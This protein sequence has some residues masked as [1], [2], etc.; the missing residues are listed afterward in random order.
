VEPVERFLGYLTSIE[1]S[2]NTV[3]AYAHDLKDWDFPTSAPAS[4]PRRVSANPPGPARD[5]PRA[6]SAARHPATQS[7]RKAAKRT[8]KKPKTTP[9]R[10]KRKLRG[11]VLQGTV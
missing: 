2:P 6:Q 11:L 8:N 3:K 4:G 5:A 1:K 7:R 10:L 9:Y